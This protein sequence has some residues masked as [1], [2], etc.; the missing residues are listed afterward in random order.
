YLS[1]HPMVR[2]EGNRLSSL[3]EEAFSIGFIGTT[4]SRNK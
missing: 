3:G 1:A 4:P 2:N